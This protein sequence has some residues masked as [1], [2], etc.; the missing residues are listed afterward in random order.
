MDVPGTVPVDFYSLNIMSGNGN[1]TVSWKVG[2]EINVDQYYIQRS[3]NGI[4]FTTIASVISTESN[5]YAWT[6]KSVLSGKSFYRII[7]ADKNGKQLLSQVLILNNQHKKAEIIIAPNPVTDKK[8]NLQLSNIEKGNVVIDVYSSN[9]QKVFS[10][11]FTNIGVVTSKSV[12]LPSFCVTGI[13]TVKITLANG[14]VFTRSVLV[15]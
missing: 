14:Q 3:S 12:C 11:N 1:A 6:D 7:A 2:V 4:D 9:L 13:Y 5:T 10:T 15:K 8:I